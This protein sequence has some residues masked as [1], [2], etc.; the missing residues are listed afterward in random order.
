MRARR[1]ALLQ[2]PNMLV[3]ELRSVLVARFLLA[4]RESL[5]GARL[6]TIEA[7]QPEL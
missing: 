7:E 6:P 4:E 2:E 1:L 3:M 5:V